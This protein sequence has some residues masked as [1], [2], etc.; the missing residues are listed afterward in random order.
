M[1]EAANLILPT[2]VPLFPLP[3]V[4]LFPRGI[5]PLHVFEPRYQRLTA[6]TIAGSRYI[7]IALLQPGYEPLYYTPRAPIH[8]VIAVGQILAWEELEG[9]NYNMLVRGVARA[10]IVRE[11]SKQPY[12]VARV[13]ARPDMAE[14]AV[15]QICALRE[16]L[17]RTI[18]EEPVRERE[19]QRHW[20]ELFDTDLDL[21]SLS[22]LIASGL[23][24]EPELRFQ[25]LA[26]RDP[27]RRATFLSRHIR[28]L[29]ATA[30]V[31][32]TESA[33]SE[34]KMN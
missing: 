10:R 17:R 25:L 31:R 13:E 16:D 6:D 30:R 7:G 21:G 23:P 9:G 20:L 1:S 4:V 29:S 5:L 14:Y 34:W 32:R 28:T 11:V 33:E 26:E 22:D 3:D 27:G 24:L 2:R 15:D 18:R 8:P 12:R 19:V